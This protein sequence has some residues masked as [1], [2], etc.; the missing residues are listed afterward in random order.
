MEAFLLY[1]YE[2]EAG[3]AYRMAFCQICRFFY[4]SGFVVI[5]TQDPSTMGKFHVVKYKV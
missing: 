5:R 3:I 4:L 2:L 1:D